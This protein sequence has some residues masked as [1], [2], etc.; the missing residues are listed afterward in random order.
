MK[1]IKYKHFMPI[2]DKVIKRDF[3][4]DT[5]E[6]IVGSENNKELS[7]YLMDVLGCEPVDLTTDDLLCCLSE[8]KGITN[9]RLY[10]R[11]IY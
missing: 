8:N 9:I 6:I 1:D 7:G 3:N 11:P 10:L 2:F 4:L 5:Y